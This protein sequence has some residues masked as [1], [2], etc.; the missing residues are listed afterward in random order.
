MIGRRTESSIG[1]IAVCVAVSR[2]AV[3]RWRPL[4]AVVA[5]SGGNVLLSLAKPWPLAVVIDNVLGDKPLVRWS[6]S[7]V[8]GSRATLLDW[9]VAATAAIFFLDWAGTLL[10]N[11]AQIAYGQRLAYDLAERLLAHMHRLSIRVHKERKVGDAIR[12]IT[13]DSGSAATIVID[14]LLPVS[15]AIFALVSMSAIMLHL[16]AGL[17]LVA[18]AVLPVVAVCLR[19]YAGPMADRAYEVEREWSDLYSHVEET[20]SA[21]PVVQ[22]FGAEDEADRAMKASTDLVIGTTLAQT[23]TGLRF[24]ITTGLTMALGTAAVFWIGGGAA[25]HGHLAAGTIIVFISYM[26]SLYQPVES[27]MYTSATVQEAAAGVRRVLEVL[28]VDPEVGDAP[29]ATPLPA[30]RGHIVFERVSFAYEPGRPVLEDVSFEVCPGQVVAVVGAT[31]AGKSTL[32]GMVPRFYDPTAGRVLLDGRDLRSVQLASLRQ[33]V[34]VV[35]QESFLF[36]VSLADNIAYGRPDATRAEVEAAARAAN[37]AEFIE[38]LPEGYDS[39]VGER[40]ATLS[41]GERQRV[42]IARALLK[43]APVLVLDEPTSAL[44][45]ATEHYLL[46][47]LDQ[48]MAGRTTIVIAHRLSTIR[49]ADRIVVLSSGR[50]AETGTHEELLLAGGLY[51]HLSSLQHGTSPASAEPAPRGDGSGR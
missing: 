48:L 49:R 6:A 18:L 27:I 2:L 28:A 51:A 17:A 32:V 44:D 37:A 33:Q 14:G 42:A 19:R 13:S 34:S 4:L 41:G 39:V 40:G 3:R 25:I 35:L 43:D 45:A 30:V 38:R 50:V 16:D 10:G 31:G 22:A 29:G 21:V 23:G 36:P 8:G 5:T 46:A 12:R 15:T 9:A 20:L 26:Y 24:K 11:Y 1:L 47:A 7:L